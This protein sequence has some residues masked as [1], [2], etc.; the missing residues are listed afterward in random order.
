MNQTIN[1]TDEI[2]RN[3]NLF[4]AKCEHYEPQSEMEGICVISPNQSLV[5]RF[6]GECN[7]N[8]ENCP[9]LKKYNR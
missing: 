8:P 4:R 6:D 5:S 7:D 9:E 3:Y 2:I 1:L